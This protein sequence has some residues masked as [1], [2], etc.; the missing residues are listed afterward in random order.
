M[1]SVTIIRPKSH[2]D[3]LDI[4]RSGIGSSEVAS[5]LGLNPFET[6]YQLWRKKKG[7]DAPQ[8]ETFAMKAGHYLEDAV[9]L[10]FHDETGF[11]IIKRSSGDWIARDNAR[12]FLQV[13][14]DRT[15]WLSESRRPEDKGILECK[16]TQKTIDG[17][18][19]PRHWFCQ[20]QYQLGV[21]GYR[22][23]ALA[24]L[25]AGRDFG[26]K[27]IDFVPDFYE[28]MVGEVEKFWRDYIEGDAEPEA[29]DVSDAV[30][31]Y[32]DHTEGKSVEADGDV[33]AA[34]SELKGVKDQLKSLN[35]RKC[36]LEG[37]IKMSLKDAEVLNYGG[38]TIAT[39]KTSKASEKFDEAAFRE[40]N[41][42]LYKKYLTNVSGSRR[43]IIK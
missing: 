18:D 31:K 21:A 34:Y 8:N 36:E 20:L 28:W 6:P 3:W 12:P 30:I 25:C 13:S 4:R 17:D 22:Q 2:G 38:T 1:N 40:E 27:I 29:V 43:L 39:W 32:A 23:G 9:S 7:L 26:Y 5:I 10:F 11:D 15:Y 24:W 41:Q 16:T 19:L 37:L 33:F 14:P 42:D 35:E